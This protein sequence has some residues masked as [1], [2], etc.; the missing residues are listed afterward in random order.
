MFTFRKAGIAIFGIFTGTIGIAG[1]GCSSDPGNADDGAM[2]SAEELSTSTIVARAEQWSSAHLLYCQSA[3]GA[4][5]YDTACPSY[6]HRTSND[7]WDPY[8][9]DCSGLISWAWGLPAPGR[10]TSQFAPYE[11]D[12]S[13]RISGIDLRPGDALNLI[14]NS[15]H[16]ILFK[17]WVSKG[18]SAQF[19][20]E[21]GCSASPDYAHTFTSNVTISGSSVYV[22]YEGATFAAIRYRNSTLP[23]AAARGYLDTASCTTIT[24]WSEDPDSPGTAVSVNLTFDAP[25][26]KSGSGTMRLSANVHRTDLCSAIGSCNHGYSVAMPTGV[27]DGKRHTVYAYGHDV[28]GGATNELN[29]APKTFTCAP[30]AIPSGVKR[31][32]LSEAAMR[33]WKFDPLLD[34]AHEPATAVDAITAAPDLEAKPLVVKADDGTASVWVIDN[35]QKRHVLN[36]ASLVAWGFTVGSMKAADV[37]A[38]PQG[39]DWP[40]VP[41][42]VQGAGETAIYVLDLVPP[43]ENPEGTV[44]GNGAGTND[45]ST[46]T[47]DGSTAAD[48]GQTGDP[49]SGSSNA[50]NGSAESSGCSISRTHESQQ[51]YGFFAIAGLG[52]ALVLRGR[53]KR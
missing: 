13:T 30:P 39:E 7:A 20:E 23:D 9:S 8:R 31:H 21:P 38:L 35:A 42:V 17:A 5:D 48:D 3:N 52:L 12:I 45:D 24:G 51:N 22:S 46:D 47:P 41:F 16:I 44:G 4:R 18:H 36:H 49:G 19:I 14:P 10:V 25:L 33:A 2:S 11:N 34:V 37:N 28:Q 1:T 53:K 32:I 6:C 40:Q 27:R 29:Q 15:E 50:D 43:V 26:G